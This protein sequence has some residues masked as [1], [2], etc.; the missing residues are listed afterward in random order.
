MGNER[1]EG[2]GRSRCGR[3]IAAPTEFSPRPSSSSTGSSSSTPALPT[4]TSTGATMTTTT[5]RKRTRR[6]TALRVIII[7][8]RRLRHRHPNNSK[9]MVPTIATTNSGNGAELHLVVP[10]RR[11]R[12][13]LLCPQLRRRGGPKE[14]GQRHH[15]G[16]VVR[17]RCRGRCHGGC[18][19]RYRYVLLNCSSR[20][21]SR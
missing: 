7:L 21:S 14:R 1:Q 5:T 6:R 2:M 4:T 12:R 18:Y 16:R 8:H 17:R 19:C 3:K 15:P 13:R 11:L 20:S 9:E 10:L